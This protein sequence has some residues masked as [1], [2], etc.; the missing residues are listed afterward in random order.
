MARNA[1]WGKDPGRGMGMN[2]GRGANP[3]GA[4]GR[5]GSAPSGGGT[6]GGARRTV[7]KSTRKPGAPAARKAA[8]KTY[9]KNS[10]A[11][12]VTKV[13]PNWGG[14]TVRPS[15]K[16][17]AKR[18]VGSWGKAAGSVKAKANKEIKAERKKSGEWLYDKKSYGRKSVNAKMPKSVVS[19]GQRAAGARYSAQ[20]KKK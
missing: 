7:A 4:Y 1:S 10:G 8:Q 6:T 9:I 17:V 12:S 3:G 14:P 11:T 20:A 13:E 18:R 15:L 5:G 16:G 19:K 2:A